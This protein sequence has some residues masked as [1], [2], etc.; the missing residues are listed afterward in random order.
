M[1]K[2]YNDS[3]IKKSTFRF[4]DSRSFRKK[5]KTKTKTEI[6]GVPNPQDRK[7]EHRYIL[8]RGEVSMTSTEV[9][10]SG[11]SSRTLR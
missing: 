1:I 7:L 3:I 4:K 5:T 11:L 6:A 8:Y 2:A 10:P 9:L